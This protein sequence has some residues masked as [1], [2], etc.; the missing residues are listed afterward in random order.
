MNRLCCARQRGATGPRFT[1]RFASRGR[2]R[3]VAGSSS[4]FGAE[5]AAGRVSSSRSGSASGSG[6]P[7]AGAV[8][9]IERPPPPASGEPRAA[10]STGSR[11]ARAERRAG[12]RRADSSSAGAGTVAEPGRSADPAAGPDS[13]L[14]AATSGA[15]A[16]GRA[17]PPGG[18]G[19]SRNAAPPPLGAHSP[20]GRHPRPPAEAGNDPRVPRRAGR[21]GGEIGTESGGGICENTRAMA[22]PPTILVVDDEPDLESLIR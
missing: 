9:G 6:A 19:I 11:Q 1:G 16:G 18:P 7:P 5:S 22:P 17:V 8:F 20:F 12:R 15:D 2:E 21:P 13:G 10:R 14:G 3:R 4:G